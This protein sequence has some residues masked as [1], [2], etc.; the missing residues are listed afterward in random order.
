MSTIS[1]TTTEVPD[2]ELVQKVLRGEIQAFE[3]ILNRYEQP[4]MRYALRLLNYH[5][6]DAEDV[7]SETFIRAYQNLASFKQ[8]LSFSS[9]LYRIAHNQAVNLIK[10]KSKTL[11]IDLDQFWFLLGPKEDQFPYG[12]QDLENVLK[13]LSPEDRS[14][15]ILFHLE[16]KSLKE[17]SDIYKL[18]QNTVAVRLRRARLKAKKIISQS[19]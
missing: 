2:L 1:K 7:T 13:Q 12:K 16:E 8:H 18:S 9:W 3:K 19:L 4:I 5:Q 15:L 11:L 17:I 10:K 6:Q 14:L